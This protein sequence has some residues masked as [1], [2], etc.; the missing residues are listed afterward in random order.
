MTTKLLN[1]KICNCRFFA[2]FSGEKQAFAKVEV[3]QICL[4]RFLRSGGLCQLYSCKHLGC[5]SSS[6][7]PALSCTL[8]LSL[9]LS[10]LLSPTTQ[11]GEDRHFQKLNRDH[12]KPREPLTYKHV[13]KAEELTDHGLWARLISMKSNLYSEHQGHPMH[14]QKTHQFLHPSCPPSKWRREVHNSKPTEP[15]SSSRGQLPRGQSS[16]KQISADRVLL[17][18]CCLLRRII[19]PKHNIPTLCNLPVYPGLG[20]LKVC[21]ASTSLSAKISDAEGLQSRY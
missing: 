9:S 2:D 13:R 4:C 11:V 19:R 20:P 3:C 12:A 14:K 15:P 6:H 16:H 7:S 10:P 21:S 5:A 18:F 8:S 17:G 1:Y